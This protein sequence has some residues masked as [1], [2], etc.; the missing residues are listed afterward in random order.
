M[1]LLGI[2]IPNPDDIFDYDASPQ[3]ISKISSF[4]Y[5][6]TI[7]QL[8]E[9]TSTQYRIIQFIDWAGEMQEEVVRTLIV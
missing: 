1:A 9:C 2:S 4:K 3:E 7:V 6:S 5:R 8:Y